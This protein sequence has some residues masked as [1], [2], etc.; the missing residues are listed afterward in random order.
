[1]KT[2]KEAFKALT[3]R[4]FLYR[5]GMGLAGLT[6]AGIP[7]LA[8]GAEKKPKYGGRLRVAERFMAQGLD[9]HRNQLVT[10]EF[11]SYNLM[12]NTLTIMGPLPQVMMYPDIAKSWEISQDGR[13][14][15]FPLREGVKFH[16]GKELDS[17][18]VKYSI[19][20]VMNPA[21]RSPKAFAYRW[22][23][24]VHA[25]D[26]YHVRIKLK[27]PYGPFLTTLGIQYCPIIP[28]GWE[29][30]P[31]KPA[32]GTGPFVF[33]SL[34]PNE[35]VEFTRFD[36]YWEVDEKTGDRLPYLDSIYVKKIVD[37]NVRWVSLRAG[38]MDYI[39]YPSMKVALQEMKTPTP[40][41]VTVI[42]QPVG[43]TWIY[44]NCSRPPF[45]NKKVRQ[46]VA[47]A[48]NKEE[49]VRAAYWGLGEPVNNQPF[50]KRSRMYIPIK[51]REVDLA[52]AK[53]LLA[54]AGYPNGLKTEFFAYSYAR[55]IDASQAVMGQ[56]TKVGIQAEMK[57]VDQVAY[58]ASMRKGEYTISVGGDSERLDPDDAYYMRLHSSEIGKNNFSR[59][60]NKK[61]DELLEKGRTTWKWEDRV[62][63]YR[64]VVEMI[65]EEVPIFYVNKPVIS[66]CHRDYVKG[67]E[68]G[69][70]TWFG[71]Y[72]GG[73]K[74]VWLDK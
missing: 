62:P 60:N 27:E 8:Q 53:Q 64:Q 17:G 49:I 20:R 59:Y 74:K 12:Y 25:V 67:H 3:R 69:A 19:E 14:Y 44:F 22:I 26:K 54:E 9:A 39:H 28:A 66:I 31:L 50:L 10:M 41:I 21:T 2:Q 6:L 56:L 11:F 15:L 61:M 68:F 34:V 52:R 46:A 30:T 71:Y 5:G 23:D 32:P 18:D 47:Y 42:P 51:D 70:S 4:D 35:T 45:D 36:K 43:N 55:V 13:E 38:D 16:H 37:E 65:K 7:Q 1:M 29:P 72:G 73:M 63:I 57:V 40:G 33:K 24:S 48:L 58:N